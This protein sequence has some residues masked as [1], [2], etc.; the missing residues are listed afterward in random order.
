MK[1]GRFTKL[2]FPLLTAFALT[3]TACGSASEEAETSNPTPEISETTEFRDTLNIAM[4][5]QPPTLDS[6][7]TA[8]NIA[9]NISAH[10][11][12]P[13]FVMD[14][15]YLVTP[16][17]AT[18]YEVSE[19]GLTYTISLREGVLFHDG[20]TMTADDVV[21]SMNRW[22]LVNGRAGTA[23]AG[24]TFEAADDHTVVLTLDQAVSDAM[25]IMAGRATFAM[26]MPERLATLVDDEGVPVFLEE[27]VGTGPYT[28]GEW[29]QDQF[30]QLVRFPDYEPRG[31]AA[32]GFA[33]ARNAYTENLVFHF[34]E[35]VS[36]RIA[37]LRTGQFDIAEDIPFENAI[38][39]E[40]ADGITL[41]TRN[42]GIL[43][44]FFNTTEGILTDEQVRHAILAGMNNEEIMI[45][46]YSSP[47]YFTLN[48]NFTNPQQEMWAVE[49]G[50]DLFNQNNPERAQELLEASSYN[51]ETIRLLTTRDY[52]SMHNATVVL[53][54]Q[55]RALG[56]N[57]EI[58][59][60]DFPTF[61]ERRS[62]TS[63]WDIFITS[64]GYN[65]L[66]TQIL[67][68]DPSWAGFNSEFITDTILNIRLADSQEEATEYWSQLVQYVYDYA[69]FTPIGHFK[70]AMATSSDV[71][72]FIF[73]DHPV[74]WNARIPE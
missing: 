36:T 5:A 11:F 16:E 53:D 8:S 25:Q 43:N 70:N 31:G 47:D 27:F 24:A 67:A 61:M 62:G 15:N 32:S 50:R 72:G 45:G 57:T 18:G 63:D 30:I 9:I 46:G 71:E 65:I 51:G 34:V 41:H 40:N 69:A 58:I 48:H 28:Y 20:T 19:D 54:A 14:E 56:F 33:G 49:S 4:T 10:I 13:L 1:T 22:L 74:Y 21:A 44:A 12:E 3:L 2:A 73:F 59:N 37:G 17:L 64:N 66:P 68:L 52:I 55:L 6:S 35:D 38:D 39:L 7:R 29:R 42:A 26:I 60:V 23:L